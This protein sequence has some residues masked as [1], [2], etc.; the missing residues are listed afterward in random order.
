[1]ERRALRTCLTLL[2]TVKKNLE[3][4]TLT[5]E[6]WFHSLK[7]LN[8]DDGIEAFRAMM[9]QTI[10]GD[11]EPGH[12]LEKAAELALV[13]HSKNGDWIQNAPKFHGTK[14]TPEHDT[15]ISKEKHNRYRSTN[16]QTGE[17][18]LIQNPDAW[19]YLVDNRGN[20]TYI[21]PPAIP[22]GETV[23]MKQAKSELRR[24]Q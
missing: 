19:E 6:A 16:T 12:I 5:E 9:Q 24:V 21:R 14:G 23:A 8:D 11:V 4:S 15:F 20:R 3:L 17:V 10:Y 1:M 22:T 7:N 18:F 13:R 2:S